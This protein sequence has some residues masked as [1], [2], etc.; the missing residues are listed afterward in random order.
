MNKILIKFTLKIIGFINSIFMKLN[1]VTYRPIILCYHAVDYSGW[2]FSVTPE[3]FEKQMKFLSEN[4]QVVPLNNMLKNYNNNTIAITFDDGYKSVVT[5]AL[6]IM[7]KFNISATIFVLGDFENNYGQ[8]RNTLPLLTSKEIIDLKNKKFEIGF[9]TKTHRNLTKID[10]V[11]LRNETFKGKMLLEQKIQHKLKYFAYPEGAY[12]NDVKKAVAKSGFT[13]A[14]TVN[15]GIL[16]QGNDKFTL[17]RYCIGPDSDINNFKT[18]I[19]PLGI[20]FSRLLFN[21]YNLKKTLKD[22]F[23]I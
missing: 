14:F 3:V 12:N 16:K 1:I 4:L 23:K 6:P 8:L 15:A 2:E 9:H 20:K 13:F 5:N 22:F 11:D 18:L 17:Q 19:T 10:Y 7:E 21:M